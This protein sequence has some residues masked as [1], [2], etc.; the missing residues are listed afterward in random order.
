V[1]FDG[2]DLSNWQA[3]DGSP[4]KWR[5][6]DGCMLPTK[7]S[8]PIVTKTKFGDV[9][10][11][12]EW[13]APTP[14]K[15]N[16]QARG[17]SGVYLMTKYEVQILDSYENTTY[18]DG[19]A[20]ALYG[21][22][23]PLVNVCRPPGQW[24]VY[25]IVFRRPKFNKNGSLAKPA[26]MT[27]F[28]NGVLVQDHFEL[29]GPTN[30]LEKNEYE[31]HQDRL[32]ISLQDHGNP[33]RFR[34]IWLRELPDQPA[35]KQATTAAPK[36]TVDLK[37]LQSYVGDYGQYKV[38][39]ADDQLRLNFFH[40]NFDLIPQTQTLFH[41]KQTDAHVQFVTDGT[42]PTAIKVR[43]MDHENI[44]TRNE[45]QEDIQQA[46]PVH[47]EPSVEGY[48]GLTEEAA[49]AKA[50]QA[51]RRWRVVQRD[52][53][54]FPVTRD[55]RPHRLNFTVKNGKVVNVTSG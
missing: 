10:L 43:L 36:A 6:E 11:H 5:V 39:L 24:Q 17:N 42:K 2:T 51:G 28:H 14:P 30:W 1:L 26:V 8:G 52:D 21:Q 41:F 38:R 4:S 12:V 19:Q 37:T 20:A 25:D 53:Q 48:V 34:N 32:P 47:S 3:P 55:Y 9:Q 44:E 7:Q 31:P 46:G 35:Y 18:A 22:N 40:R 27:V 45:D 33:V 16:G 49:V 29:W 23:P 15:G 13:S 54:L 50:K